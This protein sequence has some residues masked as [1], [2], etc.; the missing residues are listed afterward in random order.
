MIEVKLHQ[1]APCKPTRFQS[2]QDNEFEQEVEVCGSDA[3]QFQQRWLMEAIRGTVSALDVLPCEVSITIQIASG[4]SRCEGQIEAY[5]PDAFSVSQEYFLSTLNQV[6][7]DLLKKFP[8]ASYRC[9]YRQHF[10]IGVNE[11]PS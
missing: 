8:M 1:S 4:Q 10:K 9:E 6:V 3:A 5:T 2:E 7:N 11:H